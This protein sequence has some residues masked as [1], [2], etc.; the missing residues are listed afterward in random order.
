VS[1]QNELVELPES[2]GLGNVETHLIQGPNTVVLMAE[3]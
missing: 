1:Y 3:R 2:L